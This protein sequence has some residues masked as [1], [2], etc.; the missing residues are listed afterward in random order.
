[1]LC[2]YVNLV[3]S[4]YVLGIGRASVLRGAVSV[5]MHGAAA[6]ADLAASMHASSRALK[7]SWLCAQN[8]NPPP[9]APPPPSPPVTPPPIAGRVWPVCPLAQIM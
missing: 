7:G 3:L 1:M 8:A 2:F 9:P 5:M 4:L 6:G